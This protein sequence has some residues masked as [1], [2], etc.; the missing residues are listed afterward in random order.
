MK[1]DSHGNHGPDVLGQV[2][3]L[4]GFGQ[5]GNARVVLSLC[6]RGDGL[7]SRAG[8]LRC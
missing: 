7:Y 3:C 5:L 4:D 8:L 2:T 1:P 6:L